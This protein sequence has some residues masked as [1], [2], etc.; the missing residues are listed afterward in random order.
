MPVTNPVSVSGSGSNPSS[1]PSVSTSTSPLTAVILAP[2]TAPEAVA[3][4]STMIPIVPR[5]RRSLDSTTGNIYIERD[6]EKKTSK[7]IE[8]LHRQIY[9]VEQERVGAETRILKLRDELH[10]LQE[11]EWNIQRVEDLL[12]RLKL[13]GE[14]EEKDQG[15]GNEE[16]VRSDEILKEEEERDG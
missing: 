11:I 9:Y 1:T 15:E 14:G 10:A 13:G 2:A 3:Q 6:V 7:K 5:Q 4:S 16:D 12:G 8:F